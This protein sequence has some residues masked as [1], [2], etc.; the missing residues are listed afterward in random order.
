MNNLNNNKNKKPIKNLKKMKRNM[1]KSFG[2]S[3]KEI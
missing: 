3:L 2:R 1:N